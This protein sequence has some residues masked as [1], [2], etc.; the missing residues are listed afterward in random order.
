MRWIA[1]PL[2]LFSFATTVLAADELRGK[3][4]Y[5]ADGDTITMLDAA[6]VQHKIRLEGIDA[7]KKG[8]AFG[9]KDEEQREVAREDRWGGSRRALEGEGPLWAN[10]WRR[11]L[12]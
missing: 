5:I 12:G 8:Q 11:A 6:K 7:P 4:V 2:L 9:T 3:V 10:S 1:V